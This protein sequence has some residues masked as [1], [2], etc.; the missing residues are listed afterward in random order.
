M[1][2]IA[3]EFY[4][5]LTDNNNPGLLL[6]TFFSIMFNE[7][8]KVDNI[9]LFNRLIKIYGRESVF[10]SILDCT[11]VRDFTVNDPFGIISYFCKKRLQ[12]KKDAEKI[13]D[14]SKIE[15]DIDK[16]KKMK[17]RKKLENPFE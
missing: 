12:N 7:D 1:E 8:L 9:K 5:K 16:L 11:G 6:A 14:V 15:K 2:N 17:R 13:L 4:A 3:E 10:F